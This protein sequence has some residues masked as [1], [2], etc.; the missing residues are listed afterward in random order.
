MANIPSVPSLPRDADSVRL[1]TN[2]IALHHTLTPSD[3]VDDGT[4]AAEDEIVS[5]AKLQL[6]SYFNANMCLFINIIYLLLLI[7]HH[8]CSPSTILNCN[9]PYHTQ[10]F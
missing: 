2:N 1:S 5:R 8:S 4:A 3:D 9:Q 10:D 7:F 6:L